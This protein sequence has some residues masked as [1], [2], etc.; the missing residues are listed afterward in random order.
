MSQQIH[1]PTGTTAEVGRQ[2][3]VARSLSVLSPLF[4]LGGLFLW[5]ATSAGGSPEQVVLEQ[6][7][8]ATAPS[9]APET[10]AVVAAEPPTITGAKVSTAGLP[11]A[12][13]IEASHEIKLV[14]PPA[15][16][17][18]QLEGAG[19][20]VYA[21]N[22]AFVGSD[23]FVVETCN[24]GECRQADI[25]VDVL[26]ASTSKY[27][28]TPV[29]RIID[30]RDNEPLDPG[31]S[32]TVAL[33]G[34]IDYEAVALSV[35]L[36]QSQAAGSVQVDGGAGPVSAITVPGAGAM[37]TNLVI[38]PITDLNSVT[39]TNQAGGH[40]VVDVVGVFESSA[41]SADGRFVQVDPVEVAKLET[42]VDGREA[43]IRL[44]E[45]L[46]LPNEEISAVLALVTADVGADG[47]MV[48]LGPG[49]EA[50]DQML[51]WGKP[52]GPNLERRGVVLLTPDSDGALSFR[53]EGGSVIELDVLGYFTNSA[54]ATETA[55]LYVPEYGGQ[56][57]SEL[58]G[59]GTSVVG[60][61]PDYAGAAFVNVSAEPGANGSEDPRD[62]G[63]ASGRTIGTALAVT[64]NPDAANKGIEVETSNELQATLQLLGIFLR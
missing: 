10:T 19:D 47:G 55:G 42:A 64:Q 63:I 59:P 9:T 58:F 16:G 35:T 5:T 62:L 41:E 53:Y 34:E 8:A 37:T 56:T 22:E 48:R 57:I 11:V 44:G 7:P 30:S 4:L 50:Y 52:G 12:I 51:M 6:E 28:A 20:A 17:L 14:T 25:E 33:T 24:E 21:P 39:V 27:L 40:V 32:Q 60:V 15:N 49:V 45:L 46:D 18:V 29:T 3:Y 54:S 26:P 2:R 36:M 1:F 31:D 23:T 61:V 38:V 13:E 43:T